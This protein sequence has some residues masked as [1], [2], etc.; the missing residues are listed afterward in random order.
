MVPAIKDLPYTERLRILDLPSLY[1]RRRRGDMIAV[2]QL[3]HEGV[4]LDPEAF[5]TSATDRTTRGHAWKLKKPRAETRIRRCA[6]GVRVVN[7]WNGLPTSVVS[8]KTLNAFKSRLD[9]H[10]SHLHYTIHIND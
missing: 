2:Y 4:D 7:D 6:F 5:V 9:T 10:W 1:Y 8:A 3:L